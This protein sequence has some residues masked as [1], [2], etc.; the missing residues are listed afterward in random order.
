MNINQ[1]A[2][3]LV[4]SNLEILKKSDM[5]CLIILS[6]A[7]LGK[8]TLVMKATKDQN[9]EQGKHF[10]YR[11]SYFT[12]LSFYQTLAEANDLKSPN[13]LVLDDTELILSD[14]NIIN[15]LKSA[16]WNN[17]G[18]KRVITYNSNSYLVK[19]I[20]EIDFK[21]K[22]IMLINEIPQDNAMLNAI[23]DRSLF[24]ELRFSQN[25]IL[26]LMKE[27]IVPKPYKDLNQ[28]KRIKVWE[29]LKKH[30]HKNSDI[31]FRTLIKAYNNY[32]YSPNNWQELTKP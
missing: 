8:T 12:P 16:T 28:Q 5:N 31:S 10:I 6:K 13:L 11:N 7:G 29:Y 17:D 14:K 30:C 15:L 2:Y 18:Q 32:L 25:E 20:P 27:E 22:I 4:Y 26:N 9:L 23:K 21:G 1:K 19:E 3:K 24:V